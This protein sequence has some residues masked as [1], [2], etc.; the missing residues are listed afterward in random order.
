MT[1]FKPQMPIDPLKKDFTPQIR[2]DGI[3][4]YRTE[5]REPPASSTSLIP[6]SLLHPRPLR[7][8]LP[9]TPAAAETLVGEAMGQVCI[10]NGGDDLRRVAGAGRDWSARRGMLSHLGGPD[11]LARAG[12]RSA[13]A[14]GP[15]GGQKTDL[16]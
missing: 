16:G 1:A 10:G 8:L 9:W 5:P 2:K 6:L 11:G 4:E 15:S 12:S 7:G 14:A 3:R 13:G